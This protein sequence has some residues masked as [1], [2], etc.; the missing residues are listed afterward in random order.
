[1]KKNWDEEILIKNLTTFWD[2]FWKTISENLILNFGMRIK[3]KLLHKPG[4]FSHIYINIYF[5]KFDILNTKDRKT[6]ISDGIL[7]FPK[8]DTRFS[9][10]K[11]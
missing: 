2:E 7:T 3:C 5:G 4:K 1:M 10:K 8:W 9:K 6:N 11:T